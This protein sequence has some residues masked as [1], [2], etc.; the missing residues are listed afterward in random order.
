MSSLD[1]ATVVIAC[2]NCGT[3]YQ[4]PYGTLGAAGREVQC[5]QCSKPWHA[6]ADAPEAA[7]LPAVVP[8]PEDAMFSP[9]EEA[10]L[11]AAFE[12]A[13]SSTVPAPGPRPLRDPE[14]ERT[15]AA[16]RAAIA[17]KKDAGPVDPAQ[18]DKSRKDFARRQDRLNQRLPLARMRRTARLAALV[19]LVA[20]VALGFSL[21]VDLVTWFPSL[22]G[23]YAAIGLPVNIVGLDFEDSKTLM[24]YRGG[25]SVMQITARIRSIAA[26]PVAVPPVLVTLLDPKGGVVYE[27]TVAPQASELDP[28]EILDFSTEL[29]SPPDGAA[30]VRLSFTT[31]GAS[32][33]TT[34]A[35]AS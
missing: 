26:S 7:P 24:T 2:P 19:A 33:A 25:K 18:F 8:S 5:A 15:L 14:H 3:R 22:A 4:V 35:K 21:R 34:P 11:D 1:L 17:P 10:V 32:A 13:E 9:A 23:V 29:S 12:S 16:I 6:I 27:W 28:G 30:S 20:V 31:G